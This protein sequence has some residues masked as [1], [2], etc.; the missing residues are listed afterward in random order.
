MKKLFTVI[1]AFTYS[2]SAFAG[3]SSDYQ[4]KISEL[5][6]KMNPPR[7]TVI[8]NIGAEAVVVGT[9]AS[10]GVLTIGAA[11]AL[12]AA[13]IGAGSYLAFLAQKRKQMVEAKLTLDQAVKMK[14]LHW[15]RFVVKVQKKNPEADELD[16]QAALLRLDAEMVF[17][18]EDPRKG[19]VKLS[20]PKKMKVLVLAEI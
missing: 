18:Q 5:S 13:A 7:T 1:I 11:V 3:C 8:G 6:G 12:P 19:T 10:A 9:L 15:K 16:I 17:C 20:K 2:I 4:K 14:G